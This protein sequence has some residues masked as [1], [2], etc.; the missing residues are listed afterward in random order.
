MIRATSRVAPRQHGMVL[1]TSLLLLLVLTIL[2]VSMFRSFSIE[3]KIAGNVREKERALHAAESAQQYAEWWL[4]Q[5]NNA[6]APTV[7]CSTLLDANA[8][9]GQICANPIGPTLST[10]NPATA[11]VWPFGVTYDPPSM[12]PTLITKSSP[13]RNSYYQLPQFYITDMGA[14][15][16]GNG[17][18]FKID[19]Q[20]YGA[21]SNTVAVVE[22]TFVVNT[23]VTCTSIDHC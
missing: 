9:D 18:V 12:D 17:E 10:G 22:S 3:G 1:V 5:G 8:G 23:G 4:S 20:G 6:Q 14:S 16:D 11:G 15:F 21:T 7:V 13:S 19:A 2:A